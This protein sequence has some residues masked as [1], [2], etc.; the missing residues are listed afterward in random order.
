M[1]AV[2]LLTLEAAGDVADV[3]VLVELHAPAFGEPARPGQS[4]SPANTTPLYDE[5][6]SCGSNPRWSHTSLTALMSTDPKL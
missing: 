6:T 3:A 4:G 1:Q 2:V 5:N